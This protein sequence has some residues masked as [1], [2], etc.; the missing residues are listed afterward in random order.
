M[1]VLNVD[2]EHTAVKEA[3][4]SVLDEV[5]NVFYSGQGYG[6]TKKKK[7]IKENGR[8]SSI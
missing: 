7:R 8:G 2:S 5:C 6:V 3:T 1:V 4:I